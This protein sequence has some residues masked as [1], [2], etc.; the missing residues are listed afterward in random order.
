MA[1]RVGGTDCGVRALFIHARVH[2][3]N[4][5]LAFVAQEFEVVFGYDGFEDEIAFV[6]VLLFL[7]FGDNHG[8]Y[9]DFPKSINPINR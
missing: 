3:V 8:C 4:E 2:G 6:F 9:Q 5:G 7:G 1:G